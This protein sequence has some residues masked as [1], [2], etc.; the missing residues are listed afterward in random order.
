MVRSQW[1][2]KTSIDKTNCRVCAEATGY[3]RLTPEQCYVAICAPESADIFRV[4][5]RVATAG[6]SAAA[7]GGRGVLEEDVTIVAPMRV[8]FWKRWARTLVKQRADF[9]R[10]E[11]E[12]AVEF[13]LVHSDLMSKLRGSWLF[14]L[15]HPGGGGTWPVTRVQYSFAMWPKGV[16]GA[17]RRLPGLMDAVQGAVA[18]ESR[19]MLDKLA[20][21][22]LKM[23]HPG[24]GILDAIRIA[25]A[26]VSRAGSYKKLSQRYSAAAAAAAA[27][28]GAA[29]HELPGGAAAADATGRPQAVV[30]AH[31]LSFGAS[32]A[33]S[34]ASSLVSS[35][36]A[37]LASLAS[38]KL[39]SGGGA[40][41]DVACDVAVGGGG[42]KGSLGGAKGSLGGAGRALSRLRAAA[43]GPGDQSDAGSS[44]GSAADCATPPHAAAARALALP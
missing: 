36:S 32:L 19:Q 31:R 37:G 20:F 25:A 12:V 17:L 13:E 26:E 15:E 43:F 39:S 40:E 21:I 42:A 7:P 6:A 11:E 5:R 44:T 28:S 33:S 4:Q 1:G 23:V 34:L 9:T 38:L 10:R 27:A 35:L 30:R 14:T 29:P 22:E 8:L 3:V 18:R 2:V 41:P 24:M 16:P